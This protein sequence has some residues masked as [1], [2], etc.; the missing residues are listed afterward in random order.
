MSQ[1]IKCDKCQKLMYAD[2]RREKGASCKIGIDYT[3]GFH[4]MHL[5]KVCHRQFMTEFMKIYTPKEYD[6]IYGE[7]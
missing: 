3:D 2:S 6:G 4:R 7:E 5:C 1:M